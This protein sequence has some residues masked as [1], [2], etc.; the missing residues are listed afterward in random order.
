[1][2]L[3]H[4]SVLPIKGDTVVYP[5]A[6][7][8]AAG[9]AAYIWLTLVGAPMAMAIKLMV[10]PSP[11]YSRSRLWAIAMGSALLVTVIG[12]AAFFL[13]T[14]AAPAAVQLLI[15]R[16]ELLLG[17]QIGAVLW[18]ARSG[19]LGR[20]RL[21]PERELAL[22][23]AAVRLAISDPSARA[24]IEEQFESYWRR[25]EPAPR[26]RKSRLRTA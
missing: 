5:I 23:L 12:A 10:Q 16:P 11:A 13:A 26:Y 6:I 1:M 20:P 7:I 18:A 24:R 15:G 17:L 19:A 25:V 22:A 2:A 21:A 4:R 8:V 9:S 3:R 14:L